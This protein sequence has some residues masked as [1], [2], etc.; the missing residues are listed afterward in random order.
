[1]FLFCFRVKVW[2]SAKKPKTNDQKM[3]ISEQVRLTFHQE[4]VLSFSEPSSEVILR[5]FQTLSSFRIIYASVLFY[6]SRVLVHSFIIILTQLGSQSSGSF[7]GS[8]FSLSAVSLLSLA[9]NPSSAAFCSLILDALSR[10]L[11]WSHQYPRARIHVFSPA[12]LLSFKALLRYPLKSFLEA[13]WPSTLGICSRDISLL[14]TMVCAV[15]VHLPAW[16]NLRRHPEIPHPFGV[17]QHK[18]SA[19]SPLHVHE[20]RS[21]SPFVS[22][23]CSLSPTKLAQVPSTISCIAVVQLLSCVQLLRPHGLQ[24]ARLF[25]P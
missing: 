17:R 7:P 3:A 18:I 6:C 12:F 9:D 21:E 16:S 13:M 11:S 5:S 24:P 2:T 15:N 19:L 25:C 1:M 10:L 22:P 8:S 14:I 4:N 20:F 23:I